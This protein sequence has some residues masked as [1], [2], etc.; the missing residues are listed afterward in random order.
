MVASRGSRDAGSKRYW[1]PAKRYGWG[2]GPPLLW[3]GWVVIGG[4]FALLA[5][6]AMVLLPRL[7]TG[8]FLAYTFVLVAVLIGVCW[9][10]GEP[11]RWRWGGGDDDA[12]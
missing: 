6:G 4:F 11:P 3:Q 7:A 10:T 9:V 2:W 8:S 5:L 1:F 12:R